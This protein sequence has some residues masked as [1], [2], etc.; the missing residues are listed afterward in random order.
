MAL[1]KYSYID[2]IEVGTNG[3]LNVRIIL[4]VEED[5]V[6]LSR[7]YHRTFIPAE[8]GTTAP[9]MAAVNEHL[10]HMK[11]AP[12]GVADLSRLESIFSSVLGATTGGRGQR[13][14]GK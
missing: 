10:A 6:E 7:R 14:R 1:Q 8:H 4:C 13:G 9:Q 11:E 2:Q 3:D 5:G 12:V